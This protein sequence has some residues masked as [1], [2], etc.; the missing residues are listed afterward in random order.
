MANAL[1]TLLDISKRKGNDQAIGLLEDTI[2]Y[3]PELSAVMGR[4]I[5]GILYET[6]HRTLPTVGFRIANS[7]SSTVK[8]L[9]RKSL[10]ECFI[11]DG[12]IQADTAVIGAAAPSSPD[13]PQADIGDPLYDEADGVI[14][15][16][17]ITVGAQMYYGTSNDANGF[18]GIASLTPKL[19]AAKNQQPAV[20]GA[21]GT[22]ANV[23]SSAYMIWEN[24][25]GTHFVFGKNSGITMMP[26]W[27]IQQVLDANSK[28][29]TALV[30]NIQ[31][32]LGLAVNM[33]LSVM[34]IGNISLA[35]DS[36]P[37]TDALVAQLLSY[38]PLQ[39]RQEAIANLNT[40]G[41]NKWGPGLK[42]F[43]NP[44][45]AYSLQQSRTPVVSG[46]G[47]A[48]SAATALQFPTLPTESNGIPLVI[49]DSITSTEAVL[50]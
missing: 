49:T 43:I 45:V 21:G 44:Q 30:N 37:L 5:D 8:G 3:A 40:G 2:T 41:P 27:R 15:A 48:I 24:L 1:L 26:E 13:S 23:Q 10:H 18:T 16:I 42:M 14:R 11:I 19:N 33:P 22:T 46:A 12:Q 6:V 20:V 36:K 32:W 35:T 29:Y 28:P 25:R 17:Y 38:I 34:R 31:G 50:T 4:P 7:G 9:Y 47:T 39:M